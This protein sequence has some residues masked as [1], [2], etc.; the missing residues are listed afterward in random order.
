MQDETDVPRGFHALRVDPARCPGSVS[1]V[2]RLPATG[3]RVYTN[4][5]TAVVVRILG[6]TGSGA[7]LLELAMDDG[8]KAPFFASA[9][10]IRVAPL[11]GGPILVTGGNVP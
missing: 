6:R 2:E 11:G 3:E 9:A 8:R 1:G 10:N 5:G 4:E 7:R